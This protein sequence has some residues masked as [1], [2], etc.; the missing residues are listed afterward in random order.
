MDRRAHGGQ[1]PHGTTDCITGSESRKSA[2]QISTPGRDAIKSDDNV[3]YGHRDE[4]TYRNMMQCLLD[5]ILLEMDNHLLDSGSYA[6]DA[7]QTLCEII[8][9]DDMDSGEDGYTYPV[10]RFGD[11]L[12]DLA[13][14]LNML[15]SADRADFKA[16][17]PEQYLGS[18]EYFGFD[19]TVDGG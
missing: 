1:R 7:L 8:C 10:P 13:R 16:D 6:V 14:Q 17:L 12:V 4:V 5:Q 2:S 19:L 11:A 9:M 3:I 18:V 15:V